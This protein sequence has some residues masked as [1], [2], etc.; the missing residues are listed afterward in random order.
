VTS[1]YR[2]LTLKEWILLG[3]AIV[4]LGVIVFISYTEYNIFELKRANTTNLTQLLHTKYSD[5]IQIQTETNDTLELTFNDTVSAIGWNGVSFV[6][7]NTN[8]RIKD[9]THYPSEIGG[10]SHKYVVL[11]SKDADLT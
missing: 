11:L 4:T 10:N 8:F 3:G 1:K 2:N 9:V 6:L 7:E 5:M